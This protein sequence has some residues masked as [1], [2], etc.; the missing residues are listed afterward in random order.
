[1]IPKTEKEF[2]W[3]V[4]TMIEQTRDKMNETLYC[5]SYRDRKLVLRLL[6]GFIQWVYYQ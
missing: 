5:L 6:K 2:R 4:K 3:V 1:M